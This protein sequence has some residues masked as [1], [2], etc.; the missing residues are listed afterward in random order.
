ML[1][2]VGPETRAK[3]H[4]CRRRYQ[5]FVEG[6]YP[7]P[8]DEREVDREEMKHLLLKSLYGE[9][10]Y[11]APIGDYPQKIIDLG[12]GTGLWAIEGRSNS[13]GSSRAG[14]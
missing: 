5:A 11:H 10:I 4:S 13:L 14:C 7:L 6:R 1:R 8:N 2:V 9:K 3:W 12:T